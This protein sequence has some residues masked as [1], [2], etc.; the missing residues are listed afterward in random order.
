M[1]CF[2]VN[3]LFASTANPWQIPQKNNEFCA[4]MKLL[5]DDVPKHLLLFYNRLLSNKAVS[6]L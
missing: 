5:D 6:A 4:C 2:D 3:K 1:S